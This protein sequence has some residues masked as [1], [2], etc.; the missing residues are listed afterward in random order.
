M[1]TS[2]KFNSSVDAFRSRLYSPVVYNTEFIDSSGPPHCLR[3]KY[4]IHSQSNDGISVHVENYLTLEESRLVF[5]VD[6]WPSD[7][8]GWASAVTT[9]PNVPY[10][11]FRVCFFV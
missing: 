9:L 3:F 10:K 1:I 4:F 6:H 8:N 7:V 11:Q 2:D 5:R